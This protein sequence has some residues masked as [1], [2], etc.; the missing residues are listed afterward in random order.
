[1]APGDNQ[2]NDN[3]TGNPASARRDPRGVAS[4]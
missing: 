3:H 2:L 1:V 4:R